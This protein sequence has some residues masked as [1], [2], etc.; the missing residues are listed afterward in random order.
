LEVQFINIFFTLTAGFC[1]KETF[2]VREAGF[3]PDCPVCRPKLVFLG[4]GLQ[5]F[6]FLQAEPG[7]IGIWPAN[8]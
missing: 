7:K 1:W 4:F 8:A 2:G 6:I 5:F 3:A